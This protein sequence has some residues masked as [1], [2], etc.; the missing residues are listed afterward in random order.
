MKLNQTKLM[1]LGAVLAG[2]AVLYVLFTSYSGAKMAVID[3]AEELGG[4]GSMA[5]ASDGGPYMSM[6]HGVAGNSVAVTDMQG[7]T[8]SSQQTYQETTLSS[9]ELLPKSKIGAD[10]RSEERRVGKG[11]RTSSR[12]DTTAISTSSVSLR[13]SVTRPTTFGLSY[14]I[15]SPRWVLS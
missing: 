7:R 8:P 1:R 6:P 14:P 3:K 15:P 11:D 13:P 5:P 12:R 9:S 10:W 4:S 2:V